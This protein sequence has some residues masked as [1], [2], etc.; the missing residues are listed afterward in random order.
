[1]YA[2]AFEQAPPNS[3]SDSDWAMTYITQYNEDE[4]G[5]PVAFSSVSK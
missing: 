2:K 3:V 1:M 5:T 4:I